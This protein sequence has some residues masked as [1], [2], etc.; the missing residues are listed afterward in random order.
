MAWPASDPQWRS[1]RPRPGRPRRG[2]AR[3]QLSQVR[4]SGV[5]VDCA[6]AALSRLERVD[7]P[8]G[9]AAGCTSAPRVPAR[10]RRPRSSTS[11]ARC[12]TGGVLVT[13]GGLP[14]PL[15]PVSVLLLSLYLGALPLGRDHAALGVL[16]ARTGARGLV[17]RAGGLGDRRVPARHAAL[18]GFR[19]CRSATAR[20]R[21]SRSRRPRAWWASY[22]VSLI[23][24]SVN[25]AIASRAR[26]HRA[27]ALP[28]AR[29]HRARA[30]RPRRLGDVAGGRRFAHRGR[31]ARSGSGLIQGNVEQRDKVGSE[32][33]ADAFSRPTSR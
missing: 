27:L 30:L 24:A 25:A 13:F 4:P 17:A 32:P 12:W 20:S 18:G 19:G 29:R 2:A 1:S 15:G 14:A 11:A 7:G 22:G 28:G 16:L 21:C 9:A 5:R 3:P 10:A 31:R 26:G 6:G 8:P 23:V 33:G